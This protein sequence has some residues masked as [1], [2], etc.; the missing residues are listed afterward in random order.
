MSE[1]YRLLDNGWIVTLHR[2]VTRRYLAFA[3]RRGQSSKD[4]LPQ[5]DIQENSMGGVEFKR[6]SEGIPSQCATADTPDEAIRQLAAKCFGC[7][8]ATG[9]SP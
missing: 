7:E 8:P 3:R 2:D 4:V 1:L 9:D 5:V 6:T